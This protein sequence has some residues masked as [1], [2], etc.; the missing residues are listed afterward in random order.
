[1]LSV[2]WCLLFI[3]LFC[4][5]VVMCCLLLCTTGCTQRIVHNRGVHEGSFFA[6]FVAFCLST[7]KANTEK[8]IGGVHKGG[9]ARNNGLSTKGMPT[10]W[11]F[12]RFLLFAVCCLLFDV[13][14]LLFAVVAVVIVVAVVAVV[15]V[16]VVI[17]VV[18]AAR[19]RKR[20]CDL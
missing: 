11:L 16:I 3:F 10:M 9:Y 5:V 19:P 12:T 20:V 15:A 18:A 7:C 17:A 14:C 13:C 8:Q 4:V 2:L 6:F 1:M